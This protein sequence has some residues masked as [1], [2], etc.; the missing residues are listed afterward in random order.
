MTAAAIHVRDVE[1]SELL[2]QHAGLVRRSASRLRSRLPAC[3]QTEDLIQAGMIVLLEA[4]ARYVE[5]YAAIRVRGA[6]LDEVRNS[7]WAPRSVQ[8]KARQLSKALDAMTDRHEREARDTEVAEHLGM[9]VTSLR[10][11]FREAS[12]RKV[13]S[14]E[15][16]AAQEEVLTDRSEGVFGQ[17][18][19]ALEKDRFNR[20]LEESIG[21]LPERERE[22]VRLYHEKGLT[23][24]AIGSLMCVSES[25]IAQMHSRALKRIKDRMSH[26]ADS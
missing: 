21:D 7:E 14:L 10:E 13:V 19:G 9:S 25:R 1:P 23:L 15:E 8:R 3:V 26:W 2:A 12:A 5:T 11:L 20:D 17:P 16:M 18:M 6:M 24:R 4:A 22:V